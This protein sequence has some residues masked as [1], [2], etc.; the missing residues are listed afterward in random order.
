MCKECKMDN[1]E[2]DKMYKRQGAVDV[3]DFD[4]EF[5]Y[6]K[7][8][9]KKQF[10]WSN[11]AARSA[12]N[13]KTRAG[14]PENNLKAH[15][16]VWTTELESEKTLFFQ[17][18]GFHKYQREVCCGCR[19]RRN[20]ELSERYIKRKDR[21]WEKL[22]DFPK[23]EPVARWSYRGRPRRVHYK[24]FVWEEENEEYK[25]FKKE[26]IDKRGIF[27]VDVDGR[28]LDLY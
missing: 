26:I 14:C 10:D 4:D 15:E 21:A 16:Y 18:F 27:G 9:G 13:K 3:S 5:R 12:R 2:V 20:T 19:K 24:W 22:S 28:F 6:V 23:G 7:P 25:N 1:R 8:G 17:F 11:K